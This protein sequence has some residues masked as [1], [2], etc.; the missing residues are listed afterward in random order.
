[1]HGGPARG[2]AEGGFIFLCYR[3]AGTDTAALRTEVTSGTVECDAM[4]E[5]E[6]L[7]PIT[8]IQLVYRQNGFDMDP[9]PVGFRF[10][11][12][13]LSP[14]G[15]DD[16]SGVFICFRRGVG[17]SICSVAGAVVEALTGSSIL[18]DM[19]VF[20]KT[21]A[22]FFLMLF[23]H[24]AEIFPCVPVGFSLIRTSTTG[25]VSKT[26]QFNMQTGTKDIDNQNQH[27]SAAVAWATAIHE[28]ETEKYDEGNSDMHL[29][30]KRK[31]LIV[32]PFLL[33]SRLTSPITDVRIVES[34]TGVVAL[35]VEEEMAFDARCRSRSFRD[36]IDVILPGPPPGYECLPV[37]LALRSPH[38]TYQTVPRG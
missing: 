30:E 38:D 5:E 31:G 15:G 16:Q 12:L 3:R 28:S 18:G 1:M 25:Y 11:C 2:L 27:S 32:H 4:S 9:P 10:L 33:I 8:E 7:L 26:A 14:L 37:D 36:S 29:G 13:N 19:C 22:D 20:F 17:A 24:A 35:D 23:V 6:V 34:P 21:H